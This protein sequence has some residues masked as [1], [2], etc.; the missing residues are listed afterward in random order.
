MLIVC[1]TS[2]LLHLARLGL[3][4]L[5]P[6]LYGQILAPVTVW[7]ELGDAPPGSPEAAL[8]NAAPWVVVV[9]D[10]TPP[11]EAL[12][13]LA[14]VDAGEAAAIALALARGADLLLI[15][16]AAGRRA[17]GELGVS[18]RGTLGVLVAAKR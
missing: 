4:D 9:P 5:L 7:A 15:D 10:A 3:L 14:E 11:T 2:P 13:V 6:R 8:A 12:V 18:V 1:D 16:D 17:A